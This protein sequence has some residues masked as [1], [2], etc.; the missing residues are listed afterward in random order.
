MEELLQGPQMKAEAEEVAEDV[1]A[2][3][4]SA[5]TQGEEVE[6]VDSCRNQ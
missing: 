1:Y 3:E 6:C 2:V 5:S 4:E